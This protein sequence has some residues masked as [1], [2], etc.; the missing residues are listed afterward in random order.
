MN[1]LVNPEVGGI[2]RVVD[3]AEAKVLPFGI[4]HWGF[5][6]MLGVMDSS[7][8]HYHENSSRLEPLFCYSFHRNAGRISSDNKRAMEIAERAGLVLRY[9]FTWEDGIFERPVNEK[10]SSI[11]YLDAFLHRLEDWPLEFQYTTDVGRSVT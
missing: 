2:T 9:G 7:G 10:D 3:W 1:I 11:R 5:L 4:S 8:W 6:N